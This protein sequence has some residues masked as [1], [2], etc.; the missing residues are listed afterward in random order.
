MVDERS[1]WAYR[2]SQ[3]AM[4]TFKSARGFSDFSTSVRPVHDVPVPTRS[5]QAAAAT[6]VRES[7]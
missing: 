6:E 5:P 1:G 2:Q 7:G 3:A 4:V